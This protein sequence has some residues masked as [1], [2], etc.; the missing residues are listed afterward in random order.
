MLN[1]SENAKQHL[2][3]LLKSKSDDPK[4]VIR[5]IST[6]QEQGKL[7]MVIDEPQNEDNLIQSDQGENILAFDS[8]LMSVLD[9]KVLDY[10]DEDKD[11]AFTLS[12]PA[13]NNA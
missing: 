1:V 11:A 12:K 7:K 4:T 13:A 5:I 9:G 2:Q 10:S 8:K 3:E 6:P